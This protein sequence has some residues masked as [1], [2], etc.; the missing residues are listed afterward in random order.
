MMVNILYYRVV[1][2][3]RRDSQKDPSTD[4]DAARARLILDQVS[5]FCQYLFTSYFLL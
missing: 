3:M 1:E 2:I 5:L 4:T